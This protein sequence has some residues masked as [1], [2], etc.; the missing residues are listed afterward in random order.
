M[1]KFMYELAEARQ[2]KDEFGKRTKTNIVT[3]N[4]KISGDANSLDRSYN[5]KI[6]SRLIAKKEANQLIFGGME[7]LRE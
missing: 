4:Q 6:I 1:Q 2:A 5:P 7:D 3:T